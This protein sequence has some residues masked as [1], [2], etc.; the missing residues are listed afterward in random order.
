ML[1]SVAVNND[2]ISSGLRAP[3]K[4]HKMGVFCSGG[5]VQSVPGEYYTALSHTVIIYGPSL[6]NFFQ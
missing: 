1:H 6:Y 4:L 3:L 2:P 5:R